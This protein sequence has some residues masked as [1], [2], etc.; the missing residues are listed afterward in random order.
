MADAVALVSGGEGRCSS[1]LYVD[2]QSSSHDRGFATERIL[3]CTHD[4]D[5]FAIPLAR[6][7][8][9]FSIYVSLLMFSAATS[10]SH[11]HPADALVYFS[12]VNECAVLEDN[13][14]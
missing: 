2:G 8:P 14:M 3:F 10:A 13:D 4:H 7:L 6:S 1:F 12:S 5:K 9:L 11:L